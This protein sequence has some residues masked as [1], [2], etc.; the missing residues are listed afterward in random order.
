MIFFLKEQAIYHSPSVKGNY[1]LMENSQQQ[2]SELNLEVLFNATLA[3][4][5]RMERLFNVKS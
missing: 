3:H 2:E 5:E 4:P 1:L